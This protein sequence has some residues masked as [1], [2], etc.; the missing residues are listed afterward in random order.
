MATYDDEILVRLLEQQQSL[1]GTG[2]DQDA[3]GS[4]LAAIDTAGFLPVE[5]D[6]VAALDQ[7]VPKD[8]TVL[9]CP[10]CSHSWTV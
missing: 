1:T 9:H 6:D 4:L 8:E 3:F 5:D 7:L 2:Y 10:K